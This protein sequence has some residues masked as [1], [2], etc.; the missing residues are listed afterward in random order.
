MPIDAKA[1]DAACAPG[2]DRELLQKLISDVNNAYA[3]AKT[4]LQD[5]QMPFPQIWS[6]TL[7]DTPGIDLL[8]F[9]SYKRAL[10]VYYGAKRKGKAP[11]GKPFKMYVES[12]GRSEARIR[13]HQDLSIVFRALREKGTLKDKDLA[14]RYHVSHNAE[15]ISAKDVMQKA[16]RAA[17]VAINGVR[18]GRKDPV[19][20]EAANRRELP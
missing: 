1:L 8:N 15:T 5:A 4:D 12:S 3:H 18:S 16:S 17:R 20:L 2:I 13:A 10:G 9:P 14:Y 7:L 6:S 19:V 11:K